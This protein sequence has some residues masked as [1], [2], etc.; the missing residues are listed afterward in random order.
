[1]LE[2]SSF[3]NRV[4]V[5]GGFVLPQLCHRRLGIAWPGGRGKR[6]V[7][8]TY[9]TVPIWKIDMIGDTIESLHRIP[10]ESFFQI[11]LNTA[12]AFHPL[13]NL[14]LVVRKNDPNA[15]QTWP[16]QGIKLLRTRISFEDLMEIFVRKFRAFWQESQCTV[17]VLPH[18]EAQCGGNDYIVAIQRAV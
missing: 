18:I 17:F 10:L 8:D 16:V 11:A 3:A 15:P 1:M 7:P 5:L 6:E 9:D 14:V 2:T 4:S 13:K 12:N